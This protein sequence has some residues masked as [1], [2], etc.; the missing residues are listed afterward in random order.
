[1][2]TSK[3][4]STISYN[5][6]AFLHHTLE[7]LIQA[8]TIS[9]YIFIRHNAEED[10]LKDH[11]H[12]WI[13]PNKLLD[14][15]D[16]QDALRELDLTDPSKKPLGCIDFTPSAIDDWIL[17]CQHYTPY[18]ETKMEQREYHYAKSDFYFHDEETFERYYN[19][20]FRGS[21]FSK[22]AAIRQFLEAGGKPTELLTKG[23]LPFQQA[24]AV[25]SYTRL[26]ADERIN[27][28]IAAQHREEEKRTKGD[29][30]DEQ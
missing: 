1:M 14:T 8:H 22:S 17:Y 4:I 11:I 23:V 6:E 3:P 2:R 28:E 9:D 21:D 26:I 15:M 29:N 18:L 12:L 20:A 13:K 27:A 24:N 25:L 5:S 19:H 10:D 7:N 30:N 16:L